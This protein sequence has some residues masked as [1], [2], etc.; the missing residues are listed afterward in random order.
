MFSDD[1]H[2]YLLQ[3]FD[4]LGRHLFGEE[5]TGQEFQARPTR[6]PEAVAAEAAPIEARLAE[7][8]KAQNALTEAKRRTTN[9]DEVAR[10]ADEL[11]RLE[12]ERRED[13]ASLQQIAQTIESAHRDWPAFSR[14]S[15]TYDTLFSA[16][17]S[18]RLQAEAVDGMQIEWPVWEQEPGFVCYLNLSL[19]HVA[20]YRSSARR[21][22]VIIRK[23]AFETWRKTVD[24]IN[25]KAL[26]EIPPEQRCR[27]WLP[28]F[29]AAQT[30]PVPKPDVRAEAQQLFP[31]LST[32]AFD[33]VWSD[34]APKDR[35]RG[36]RPKA[37]RNHRTPS[38]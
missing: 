17:R 13:L 27:A 35:R 29:M 11:E 6:K 12:M 22:S 2:Y 36:G 10:L 23:E 37:S 30:L 9:A 1:S 5:W 18:E 20:R 33:R 24:P 32:R 28:G 16:L 26:A 34:T 14:H 25:E 8:Q 38:K 15:R 7:I 21:M 19:V 31:G 3:A 4:R